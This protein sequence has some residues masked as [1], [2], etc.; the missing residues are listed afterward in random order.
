MF[1]VIMFAVI[2]LSLKL[3]GCVGPLPGARRLNECEDAVFQ[4]AVEEWEQSV[5]PA[6]KLSKL[7]IRYAYSHEEMFQFSGYC[8]PSDSE[9]GDGGDFCARSWGRAAGYID[10]YSEGAFTATLDGDDHVT[11]VVWYEAPPEIILHE[12]MHALEFY[13]YGHRDSTHGK[14]CVWNPETAEK[15]CTGREGPIWGPGG[16][17]ENS[18]RRLRAEIGNGWQVMEC[19]L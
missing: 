3:V 4:I 14:T 10:T 15:D 19:D 18:K 12:G 5:G 7:R 11:M 2:F 13:A 8:G 17:F 6:P 1:R 9:L 16:A